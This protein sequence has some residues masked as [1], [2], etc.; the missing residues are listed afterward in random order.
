M[1]NNSTHLIQKHG[2]SGK[3]D[4]SRSNTGMVIA[5]KNG[6]KIMYGEDP[7]RLQCREFISEDA[8]LDALT[9]IATVDQS[10]RMGKV[11]KDCGL[12]PT[13]AITCPRTN[14]GSH[15]I[16]MRKVPEIE[17]VDT[18]KRIKRVM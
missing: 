5:Y 9:H 4:L 15:R 3:A 18:D 13:E 17:V 12:P 7:Q 16:E 8:A 2:S 10:E 14:D 6:T 1:N 11:C